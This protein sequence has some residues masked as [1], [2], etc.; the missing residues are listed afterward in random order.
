MVARS[1]WSWLVLSPLLVLTLLPF[2]V[3]L[4]TALKPRD[5]VLAFPPRWL[6]T[7]LAW[8]NFAAMWQATDF[9]TGLLNSLAV[10]VGGTALTLAVAFPAAYAMSRIAFRGRDAYGQFLL[11][12]QMLSPILLV[13]G[14][15]RMA[16][17]IHV[18]GGTLVDTR[19]GVVII[20]AGFQLAFA[21]WMLASYFATIPP[22]LEQA[23][24]IDGATRV[25]AAVSIFLPLSIP[26]LA[27]TGIVTFVA[28]WNEFPGGV[29]DAARPVDA[30]LAAEGRE[31]GRRTLHRGVEPGDGR[32]PARHGA[33]RG[34][35]RRV[36]AL[37]GARD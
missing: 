17:S 35:V 26:A 22:E 15:F 8:E 28:C 2:A 3:M 37:P 32:H 20:Y 36:A 30:D 31:P 21:T 27:V 24:W 5:E 4:S 9:G 7:R 11:V 1:A 34:G 33:G 19:T 12:T 29:D 25:R 18:G 13:L 16:A 14:L 10:S 6:P 23:A